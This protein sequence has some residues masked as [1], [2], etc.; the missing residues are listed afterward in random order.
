MPLKPD[1]LTDAEQLLLLEALYASIAVKRGVLR[2]INT[3]IHLI[4]R[5]PEFAPEDL[6]IPL[7]RTMILALGGN[8]E[9]VN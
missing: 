4:G 8:D 5:R 2:Q 7:L 9:Q 3:Q 1:D 6:G